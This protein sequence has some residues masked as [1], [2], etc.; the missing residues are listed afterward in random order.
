MNRSACHMWTLPFSVH[1]SLDHLQNQ[2]VVT[3]VVERIVF[4]FVNNKSYVTELSTGSFKMI[5]YRKY[6]GQIVSECIYEIMDFPKYHRKN[7]MIS[8]LEGFI[9]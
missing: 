3:K 8:A 1:Q 9:D 7:L 2:T 5:F 4:Y 6:K